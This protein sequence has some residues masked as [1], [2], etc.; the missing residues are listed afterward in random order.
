MIRL[1]D[2][3]ARTSYKMLPRSSGKMVFEKTVFESVCQTVFLTS[4]V[5]VEDGFFVFQNCLLGKAHGFQKSV[6]LSSRILCFFLFFSAARFLFTSKML[7]RETLS[8]DAAIYLCFL[9][10]FTG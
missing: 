3:L 5:F 7:S 6:F 2:R 8:H 4:R 9:V 1:R 10:A